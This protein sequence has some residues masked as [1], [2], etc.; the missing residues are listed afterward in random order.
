MRIVLALWV[1]FAASLCAQSGLEKAVTLTREKQYAEARKA[2]VD[3]LEPADLQQRIAFHRLKAAIASGLSEPKTA[4]LE[5]RAALRLAPD[6]AKLSLAT[7]VA[8][9]QA[10]QLDAAVEHARQGGSSPT[11]QAIIGDIEDKRGDYEAA[12]NAYQL[13]VKMAPDQESYRVALALELLQHQAFK[14]ALDVLWKSEALFPQSAKIRTLIGITQYASNNQ[15]E[16]IA[17]FQQAIAADPDFEPAY[18]CLAQVL[19]ESAASPPDGTV[20][21][22]CDWN[23]VACS[24]MRLRMARENDDAMLARQSMVTLEQAPKDDAVA[25]C[26]LGRGYEWTHQWEA[27]RTEMEACVHLSPTPQNHYR[28]GLIYQKLG[29]A[30]LAHREMELRNQI[31]ARM[32][33]ETAAGMNALAAFKLSLK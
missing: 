1:V 8:E 7:A 32:T 30:D 16:A 9:M 13:A 25:R 18:R 26:E 23:P 5:M 12:A 6:S 33:D 3:V 28:L 10:G 31:Q 2:L 27:A 11:T 19:L 22:I 24:A 14:T 17:S 4:V 20:K 15:T 29:L 21:L